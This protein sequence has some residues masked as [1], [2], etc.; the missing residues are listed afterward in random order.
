MKLVTHEA[1][2]IP[3]HLADDVEPGVL[4]DVPTAVIMNIENVCINSVILNS[5]SK[6][7]IVFQWSVT[8]FIGL[9]CRVRAF[10]TSPEG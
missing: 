9:V 3:L 4:I 1:V 2:L 5:I 10:K 6:V 7:P 8:W